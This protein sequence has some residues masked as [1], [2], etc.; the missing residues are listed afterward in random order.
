MAD[1]RVAASSRALRGIYPCGDNL[2]EWL[3]ENIDYHVEES[4]FYFW[5]EHRHLTELVDMAETGEIPKYM[6]YAA[7]RQH[8]E[9]VGPITYEELRDRYSDYVYSDAMEWL[10]Y[11]DDSGFWEL[12]NGDVEDL[13]E[14]LEKVFD[15]TE[16]IVLYD[17]YSGL[18]T[19]Y[20]SPYLGYREVSSRFPD[21]AEGLKEGDALTY[22]LPADA[23]QAILIEIEE[24][25]ARAASP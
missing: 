15:R 11:V 17:M 8:N 16:W 23:E 12:T 7:I 13:E 22:I 14:A 21:Y 20:K 4:A 25:R 18:A 5:R 2:I 1:V 9:E 10:V 24:E 6:A 19:V 3:S